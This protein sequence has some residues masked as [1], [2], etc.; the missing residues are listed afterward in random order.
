MEQLTFYRHCDVHGKFQLTA[1]SV[2][3]QFN[4]YLSSRDDKYIYRNYPLLVEHFCAW[5]LN[6]VVEFNQMERL[7]ELTLPYKKKRFR[8]ACKNLS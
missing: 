2:I 5:Q 7:H 3:N 8:E 6:A 1:Q 4:Q